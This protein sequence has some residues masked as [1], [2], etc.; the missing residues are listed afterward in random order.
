MTTT[1]PIPDWLYEAASGRAIRIVGYR[2]ATWLYGLDGIPT[3]Q[4]EFAIAHGTRKRRPFDHQRRRIDDLDI[5]EVQGLLITSVPQTL[6]DLCAV[7]DLDI[8]ERAS[9]SALRM[10]FVGELELREFARG[11]AF[12]RRG[13]PGLRAVLERRPLGARPTGSDLET[14]CLQVF[15]RGGIREPVRQFPVID[16][17]GQ[18]AAVADF[19]FPP[20]LFVAET[21]GLETHGKTREQQQYDLN[22]QNRILDAGYSLRRFTHGDVIRRPRYVC[23]ETEKGLL[24]AEIAPQTRPILRR[25]G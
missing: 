3:L 8:V 10:H 21:D 22:R 4:P 15:R 7:C 12:Y 23:R 1:R 16:P 14:Q 11:H 18:V 13:L 9:E 17:N 24:V 5:V 19:G 6:V 2:A 20:K 25:A